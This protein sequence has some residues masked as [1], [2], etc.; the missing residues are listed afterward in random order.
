MDS[1]KGN[2]RRI[3]GKLHHLICHRIGYCANDLICTIVIDL[4]YVLWVSFPEGPSF[5]SFFKFV[6]RIS[7]LP[8]LAPTA[9][10]PQEG[11]LEGGPAVNMLTQC[12]PLLVEKAGVAPD[13]TLRREPPWL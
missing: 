5:P 2:R 8:K 11:C 7:L 13:V 3:A 4:D 6:D 1:L 10:C 12:T 9:A